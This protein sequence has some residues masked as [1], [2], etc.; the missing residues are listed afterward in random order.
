MEDKPLNSYV[1]YTMHT[2]LIYFKF[3]MNYGKYNEQNDARQNIL[4]I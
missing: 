3:K 4:C 2:S 1:C